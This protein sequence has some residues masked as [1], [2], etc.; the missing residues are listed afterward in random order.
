MLKTK[1]WRK[2]YSWPTFLSITSSFATL[3]VHIIWHLFAA[4][5]S[6]ILHTSRVFVAASSVR[7][8][9]IKSKGQCWT[10]WCHIR[11][12]IFKFCLFSEDQ[13]AIVQTSVNIMIDRHINY[14]LLSFVM[15]DVIKDGDC[16]FYMNDDVR[17]LYTYA[18][19][20]F[21]SLNIWFR[22]ELFLL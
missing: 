7:I 18:W 2:I 19:K 15:W 22:K 8:K 21:F 5:C 3:I 11:F 13:K 4:T 6:I 16:R 9:L 10:F 17:S 12:S 14:F 20:V 1:T